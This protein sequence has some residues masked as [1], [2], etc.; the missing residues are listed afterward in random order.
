MA[1]PAPH[2]PAHIPAV[3]SI[4]ATRTGGDHRTDCKAHEP[5][6]CDGAGSG[7]AAE[8]ALAAAEEAVVARQEAAES[9]HVHAR[10][11]RELQRVVPEGL[12]RTPALARAKP[13][14]PKQTERAAAENAV[15]YACLALDLGHLWHFYAR[16]PQR[17]GRRGAP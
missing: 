14:G 17:S 10:S 2:R 16:L 6:G 3:D 5:S 12:L 9:E 1:W 7:V 11:L 13:H 15:G 4:V 8:A